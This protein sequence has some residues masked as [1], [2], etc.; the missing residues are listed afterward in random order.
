MVGTALS[1][2]FFYYSRSRGWRDNPPEMLMSAHIVST[3]LFTGRVIVSGLVKTPI[4]HRHVKTRI[5]LI[6]NEQRCFF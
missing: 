2:W 3:Q 6:I 5:G 4:R 1:S